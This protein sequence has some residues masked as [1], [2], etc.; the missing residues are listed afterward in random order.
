[1]LILVGSG[2]IVYT[3]VNHLVEGTEIESLGFGIA[4]GAHACY[5]VM[6]SVGAT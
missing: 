2:V 5:N 6:V 3:A 4:V 1:M